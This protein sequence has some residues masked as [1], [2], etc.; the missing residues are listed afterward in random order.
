MW[1]ASE[2][3]VLW[4]HWWLSRQIVKGSPD[5]FFYSYIFSLPI[6][7]SLTY[8]CPGFYSWISSEAG[9]SEAF[10]SIIYLYSPSVLV[11]W[12]DLGQEMV[13]GTTWHSLWV[14][15]CVCVCVCAHVQKWFS[16]NISSCIS[17][18]NLVTTC[19]LNGLIL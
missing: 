14:C 9:M 15:V 16:T 7:M 2:V 5:L 10:L 6:H 8:F 4:C 1:E 17:E 11:I 3:F 19:Q 18:Y 13:W 12:T